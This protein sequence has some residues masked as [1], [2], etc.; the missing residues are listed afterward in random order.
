M[1]D[2]VEK[3]EFER[4]EKR[5]LELECMALRDF[6]PQISPRA[7]LV[8]YQPDSISK[9]GQIVSRAQKHCSTVKEALEFFSKR[10]GAILFVVDGQGQKYQFKPCL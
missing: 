5:V 2:N 1:D 4:L 7:Y 10:G 9:P 8:D 6:L 3:Y